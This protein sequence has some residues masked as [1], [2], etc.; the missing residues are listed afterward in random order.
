MIKNTAFVEDFRELAPYIH[1]LRGKTLVVAI[2]DV[3][4]D[5]Q[6]LSSLAAD[7]NLISALGIRLVLVHGYQFAV[8]QRLG[9]EEMGE[10]HENR[11]VDEIMLSV[12]QEVC[13]RGVFN[14]Q[15]ALTLG[16][17]HAPQRPARLRVSMGN[18]LTAQPM[19]VIQGVDRL[20]AGKVRRVDNTAIERCLENQSVVLIS[21]LATSLVGQSYVLSLYET[22][23]AVAVSLQAEKLIFLTPDAAILNTQGQVCTNLTAGEAR[24]M[25]DNIGNM[26]KPNQAVILHYAIE[27]VQQGVPRVQI[28]SG[29]DNGGLIRELFTRDGVGTSIARD[30]FMCVRSACERD[31]TDMIAL[32]R[33]LV[34]RGILLERSHDYFE[35][36][37]RDFFVLEHD[38]QIYGCVALKLFAEC[39]DVAE[40][41]CLVVADE[42][43]KSH[44]GDDLLA[45]VVKQAQ[46][47]GKKRLFA[48]STHTADWFLER[49]FQA[50]CLADLPKQRQAEYIA[51]GRQSKIMVLSLA[52]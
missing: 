9:L 8:N 52:A 36:H 34:E 22:A 28:L 25:L 20:Y 16:Y 37:I 42:V 2:D 19:G 5:K 30:N 40:L 13:G 10:N 18:Y 23:K 17:A 41:A 21:P 12:I 43:R 50:A 1:Y 7:F 44:Y 6:Y 3:L 32:T 49:G 15:A 11:A 46:L 27:A 4:L 29:C 35:R 31:I 48:L 24:A 33:P 51:S 38:C 26:K 14:I 39:E 45:Y 47:L